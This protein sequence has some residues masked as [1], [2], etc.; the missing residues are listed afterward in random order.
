MPICVIT[1]LNKIARYNSDPLPDAIYVISG[2]YVSTLTNPSESPQVIVL[3][4]DDTNTHHEITSDKPCHGR[5][6]SG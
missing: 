2:K 1:H 6:K 4:Y 5:G 3:N